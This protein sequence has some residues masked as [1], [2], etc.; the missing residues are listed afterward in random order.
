MSKSN[1]FEALSFAQGSS[2]KL[3]QL[4]ILTL[5]DKNNKKLNRETTI[6]IF[7]YNRIIYQRIQ[8]V[9]LNIRDNLNLNGQ[10]KN[11][12]KTL[13][14]NIRSLIKRDYTKRDKNNVLKFGRSVIFP[15]YEEPSPYNNTA[16]ILSRNNFYWALN[17]SYSFI[18]TNFNSSFAK[19][20]WE[21][22]KIR[23]ISK[24][25]Q[26]KKIIFNLFMKYNNLFN[27]RNKV[28]NGV[29][30]KTF[31]NTKNTEI[32][33]KNSLAVPLEHSE[34]TKFSRFF[35]KNKIVSDNAVNYTFLDDQL[36]KNFFTLPAKAYTEKSNEKL[37]NIETKLLGLY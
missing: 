22:Y 15:S 19:K 21:T 10:I 1:N 29:L 12:S 2:A 16:Q 32:N 20:L 8:R 34:E 13:G 30:D 37:I 26:T 35:T 36:S 5:S 31:L 11:R 25:N 14:K 6:N 33:N 17:K 24:S 9:I 7:E 4:N 23:E 3:P 18:N 28:F 27:T